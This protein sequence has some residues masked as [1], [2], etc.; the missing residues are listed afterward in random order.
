MTKK[1]SHL[2][3]DSILYKGFCLQSFH[4]ANKAID[5]ANDW[6]GNPD[7]I[8][9]FRNELE[10]ATKD[11]WT[12]FLSKPNPTTQAE[13]DQAKAE[14]A[15][16]LFQALSS[17]RRELE[18]CAGHPFL[19]EDAIF[20]TMFDLI[21]L[22]HVLKDGAAILIQISLIEVV[23]SVEDSAFFI[24]LEERSIIQSTFFHKA[25]SLHS[26]GPS[27]SAFPSRNPYHFNN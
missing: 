5:M 12:P 14:T 17:L 8:K 23:C 13:L 19:G 2:I 3:P 4:L 11:I 22:L 7:L 15:D 18:G 26:R 9:I 20:V 24:P 6:A 21:N 25:I 1:P 27:P 16:R 10:R